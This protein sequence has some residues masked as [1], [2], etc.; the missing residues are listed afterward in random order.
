MHLDAGEAIRE[1]VANDLAGGI[2]AWPGVQPGSLREERKKCVEGGRL[3][4]K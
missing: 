3:A 2:D 4:G 1:E